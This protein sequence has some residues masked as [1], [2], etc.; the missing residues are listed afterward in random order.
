MTPHE[1]TELEKDI[2]AW[3]T[4]WNEG[5]AADSL[6]VDTDLLGG[7]LLDSMGLVGL[8]SYVEDRTGTELDYADFDPGTEVTV[9]SILARCPEA[10]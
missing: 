8:I 10:E 3:I 9:R 4:D 1:V 2:L 7:G 5:L 6:E